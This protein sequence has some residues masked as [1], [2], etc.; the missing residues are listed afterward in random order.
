MPD[1]N[2]LADPPANPTPPPADPPPAPAPSDPPASGD[3]QPPAADPPAPPAKS[4]A[5]E[6][7][8][9][10]VA[11]NK[12]DRAAAAEL[13]EY[14]RQQ[15]LRNGGTPPTDPA[16][17]PDL[18]PKLSD[19]DS[20]QAWADAHT[21]WSERQIE[22]R[23]AAAVETKL[24]TRE[25]E[26]HEAT[27]RTTYQDRLR[28][29]ERA[30]PGTV[31]KIRNPEMSAAL[32]AQPAIAEVVMASEHGPALAAH[33]SDN[34]AELRRIAQMPPAQAAHA[35]GIIQ[36]TIA[37]APQPKPHAPPKPSNAPAPPTPIT[38]GGTPTINLETCSIDEYVEHRL[39]SRAV[40]KR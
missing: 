40:R 1:Q 13:V 25:R 35:L 27:T 16:D 10:L 2:T 8:E 19:F 15:A 21:A 3:P 26:A 20:T 23:A 6:R 36:A 29:Y 7:I 22:K 30:H 39:S 5:E 4:R 34:T 17:K 12:Q 28:E 11:A 31:N 37:A 32:R 18:A 33:L 14:W 9:E 38:T 24:Q